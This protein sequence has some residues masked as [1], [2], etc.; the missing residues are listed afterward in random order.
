[1]TR[2]KKLIKTD[3]ED[4]MTRTGM[5]WRDAPLQAYVCNVCGVLPSSDFFC[6]EYI[7]IYIYK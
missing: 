7:Y 3:W 5:C 1:M 4:Q 2:I 6:L